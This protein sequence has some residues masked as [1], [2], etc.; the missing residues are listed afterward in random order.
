MSLGKR[1]FASKLLAK[2]TVSFSGADRQVNNTGFPL[3]KSVMN[4]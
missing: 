4:I 1:A 2:Q 3:E